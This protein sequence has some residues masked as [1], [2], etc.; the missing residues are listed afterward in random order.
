MQCFCNLRGSCYP[1]FYADTNNVNVELSLAIAHVFFMQR[2][3]TYRLHSN[4]ACLTVSAS[5]C[6]SPSPPRKLPPL[7]LARGTVRWIA[8]AISLTAHYT[9]LALL[10]AIS[11]A[12]SNGRAFQSSWTRIRVVNKFLFWNQVPFHEVLNYG[13]IITGTLFS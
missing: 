9:Y 12:R 5:S 10:H 1:T 8:A 4:I 7:P 11:S 2:P 3:K 6:P 13:G